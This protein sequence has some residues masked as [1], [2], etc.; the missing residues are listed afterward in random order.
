MAGA[1]LDA[2]QD[3]V[4]FGMGVLHG[5]CELEAVGGKDPIVVIAG[6]DEGRR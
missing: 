1:R 4:A 2:D 6:N 5:R 3:G